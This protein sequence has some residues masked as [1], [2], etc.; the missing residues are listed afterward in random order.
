M[1]SIDH[2]DIPPL[3]SAGGTVRLPGSKSISNRVLLLAALSMGQTDI[4]DLL[5]SDDT[6]VMLAALTQLG[7]RIEPQPDGAL[8][9]HGL[10][11]QLAAR[12]AQLFLGNAGTAM[13]PLTAALALLASQHGGAFELS[14]IARMHERPI[15]DLVDAL[16]Q[17]GCPVECL[18]SEGYPP[19]KLGNGVP[20]TL[21]LDQPIRVRGDVSSQFLTALLLAL[22]LV[23][24]HRSI[25]INVVG[26]LISRPYIEIT[27]N[28]L[29]KFGVHI[30][31]DGWQRFTIPAGS[32]YAS[33]GRIPV[34]GDAS[35]ASYFIALGAIAPAAPGT[36][37]ITIE[38]VGLAS[39]QGD[40]RFVEAARLMGADI[41]GDA[42]A[43]RV[44]RGAWPL[45][46]IDLDCNH[47]PDAA[48]TLAV[49]A[50]Y[51][52][53][54]TTLRN[55]ASWRVKETDRIAAMATECRKLGATVEEGADFIRITPP[56][57]WTTGS[58][59]TYD[60]HRVAMCF[61][62]AAFNPAGLPVRIED[63]KCVGK[64][65]PDYFETL[66]SVC[67]TDAVRIPVICVDGPT[68]SGKGT[69]SA[70]VAAKLGYHLLDSGALY[71]LVG[72]AAERAGLSTTEAALREPAQ[73]Q[74]LGALAAGM[75]VRF[76]GQR[77]LLNGEDVTPAV[78]TEAAGMAASRVSA[79]PEVRAALLALQHAFRQL[80]GLVADG[81]DMGTVIF[82]D[83]RLKVYLTA[84]AA[85]RAERRHKQLISKGI[86]A[87]IED[88]LVDLEARDLRDSTRAHAPLKPAADALLLDNSQ[89]N[90][91]Q[92]VQQ[93]LNWWQGKTV[94]S[95]S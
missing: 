84:T 29:E 74:R 19:L 28:L 27:L 15:G 71:R 34:E 30:Q 46:A 4:V 64:T 33:P 26:E 31:R 1:F 23:A 17:L 51:A 92:S 6:Q 9:V 89:L 12:E 20:Q 57:A 85:Q 78:R 38:G 91:E 5:D 86:A 16:R 56:T 45:K 67:K 93:V 14:G 18:G 66:F 61:S 83:A 53:G 80:P 36:D 43:L 25:V 87:N 37:G 62:L 21:S 32:R 65:F 69:L 52:D 60:D 70:E 88:L 48:M 59:H 22:P 41:T 63:P 82:P 75:Q 8:R 2:L 49:M 42:N 39:I 81:R 40:I 58:I 68:A 11:G 73:A 44:R 55:I 13:R 10:G 35:S 90:V 95:G 94:F 24:Q 77:T 76:T 47:I 54:T 72:L 50:L 79:V 3:A 7:C